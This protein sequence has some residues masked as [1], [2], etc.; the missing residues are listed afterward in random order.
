M[1]F[2]FTEYLETLLCTLYVPSFLLPPSLMKEVD[3]SRIVEAGIGNIII[4]AHGAPRLVRQRAGLCGF[5]AVIAELV[6]FLSPVRGLPVSTVP[7]ADRDTTQTMACPPSVSRS[8]ACVLRLLKAEDC[9]INFGLWKIF[10]LKNIEFY[11]LVSDFGEYLAAISA[12]PCE[13][14]PK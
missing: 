9:V 6:V 14:C 10:S 3:S 5:D 13:F 1:C 12:E 11:F 2:N 4:R 7:E 8:C